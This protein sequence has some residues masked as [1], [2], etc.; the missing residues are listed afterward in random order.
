MYKYSISAS[1][2]FAD[3][4]SLCELEQTIS[5]RRSYSTLRRL[6]FLI[7]DDRTANAA[8]SFSGPFAKLDYLFKECHLPRAVYYALNQFRVRVQTIER[9]PEDELRHT[10]LADVRL[11]AEF[12]G[13]VYKCAMPGDLVAKLPA[14]LPSPKL[15]KAV[16]L[17]DVLRVVVV[18][19][20]EQFIYART[21]DG[22]GEDVVVCYAYQT[23][24]GDLSPVKDLLEENTRLNLV[25]PKERSGVLYPEF[26]IYEPDFLVDISTI[27]ECFEEYGLTPFSYLVKRLSPKQTS[28]AI[29]LGNFAGQFLDEEIYSADEPKYKD[30]AVRFF[31]NNALSV[32]TCT[33]FQ[34]ES[35][36][37]EAR[38][39]QQN[40]RGY[41]GCNLG[42]AAYF[43]PDRVLLEPSFFCE[44][45]G[46]QGRMDLLSEDKR[47]LVEQKSGKWCWPNGGH[48]EKHYVQ[49]LFYQAWLRY[50]LHIP[51]EEV[52]SMLLYSKYPTE[53][54]TVADENGLLREGPAP[55]LLFSAISL[56]NSI[57]RLE[58]LL[59]RGGISSLASLSAD[60]LNVNGI[61][62]KLWRDYQKPQIEG[63]LSVVRNASPLERAYF[64]RFY[65]FLEKEYHKSKSLFADSWNLTEEEKRQE[66]LIFSDLTLTEI[67]DGEKGGVEL[68]R[69]RIGAK[70][71]EC[72]PNFRR[73]DVVVCYPVRVAAGVSPAVNVCQ[74]IVYRATIKELDDEC[75]ELKLR[76]TQ[77]NKNVFREAA[78]VRWVIEHDFLDSSYVTYF[79]DLFSFLAMQN[80]E[81]KSLVLN[82]RKPVVDKSLTLSGDYGSFNDLV[83]AA[84]R[85]QDFFI[86]IGPPGTGKTSFALMNILKETLADEAASVLLV[87]YTN[88]A[89]EEIC[90]KLDAENID[91]IRIGHAHSCSDEFDQSHLLKNRI[92]DFADVK[93]L[94]TRL[95]SVRIYAGTTAS[96]SSANGLFSLK[97]FDLAIVDE[98]SQIL[99][100]HLLGLLSAGNGMAVRKFVFIGDHKQL[101]AV[102]QQ[103]AQESKVAEPELLKMGLE[104]CR[105]SFF[106]RIL[107]TFGNDPDYVYTL[108]RQG[109]MHPWVSEFVNE[110]YYDSILQS[111]P[112]KHQLSSSF[113]GAVEAK[114]D[115]DGAL[116][117]ERVFWVDVRPEAGEQSDMVNH[118]E[119]NRIAEIVLRTFL[120]HRQVGKPFDVSSVGVIV[121]YRNQ[122]SAV[123]SALEACGEPALRCITV[124]TVERFQG[125]QR[126]VIIYGTTVKREYQLDFLSANVFME[127]GQLIDRKLN[128]AISRAKEQ[129]IVVGS[130]ALLSKCQ[131][132]KPFIQYLERKNAILR[133]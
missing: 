92:K 49:M 43:D 98:A 70:D 56:R 80:D 95:R 129:M 78:G 35:F 16:A 23:E 57:A 55:K 50:N 91:Y 118:V 132:Y 60:D 104:D 90:S 19:W 121:P 44:M 100:P 33:D 42:T 85:A 126:N 116:T 119:A 10:L 111:V 13:C 64:F 31:L 131:S 124:D 1:S 3:L 65:T 93:D 48:Q 38:R 120:L 75:V 79:K 103:S 130:A 29:L 89:V 9:L 30:S 40:I 107:R 45:L 99:E 81:R 47:V 63:I 97:K 4:L 114:D 59:E 115:L 58:V 52:S 66:G 21:A 84:K 76:S 68:L 71:K 11:L 28:Q 94:T 112:L 123:R 15:R 20:D 87:S 69:F 46:V 67:S 113:Y 22:E 25:L 83:L 106:E 96:I 108:T 27:A 74:D 5:P 24:A 122:I 8:Y 109:R 133:V 77:R 53:N 34:S 128:V 26:I 32:A 73:G 36:H 7:L 39:Q 51:N 72:T 41:V 2:V 101:P 86:V 12:T 88:R 102:V 82:Q 105:Q 17:A 61:S 37:R 110:N 6:F 125:S 54:K 127:G 62:S 14:G 117:R 18:R